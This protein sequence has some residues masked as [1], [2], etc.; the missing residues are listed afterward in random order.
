M[1]ELVETA[2]ASPPNPGEIVLRSTRVVTDGEVRAADVVVAGDRIREV[3]AHG[4]APRGSG[5]AVVDLDDDVLMP[6]LVDVHVHID[7]PPP[8]PFADGAGA[9]RQSDWEGFPSASRAA[10]A[11]GIGLLVDMPLNSEPVTTS[12]AALA[13]K[14]RAAS[15]RSL[16]DVAFHAGVVPANADDPRCLASL[17]LAGAA[18]FKCFLCDSGLATFPPVDRRALRAAMHHIAGLGRR[19]LAHAELL[20]PATALAAPSA[21]GATSPIGRRYADYLDSRPASAEVAAIALLIELARD[22]GCAVHV[23]HLATAAALPLLADAR[24]EGLDITVETCPHYLTFAAE[25]IADGDTVAKC[26]P[27][28]RDAANREALWRGLERGAIDFVASDHSPCPPQLKRRE[29]GDFGAAWGGIASLQLLLPAVWT[30]V[31]ARGLGLARLAD[32][33]AARPARW[34]GLPDRG[35][36][37]PGARADLVAF[38]PE[39][40]F[41]VRGAALEHRHPLTPYEGRE[42]AGVVRHTWL[43]GRAVFADGRLSL[44]DGPAPGAP[45]RLRGGFTGAENRGCAALARRPR[46]AA[47]DL[48]RRCCGSRRW[49]EETLDGFPHLSAR[50]LYA[51][52]EGAFD[53]L[54]EADWLEAFA[55]HPRIGDRAALRSGLSRSRGTAELESAEQAGAAAADEATLAELAAG[56]ARYEE[57]FGHVFLICASGLGAGEMLTALRLR[58]ANDSRAELAIAAEEQRK[59]TALR[60]ARLLGELEL[61]SE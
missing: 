26:A 17:A 21:V 47:A 43:G 32:W 23:V 2:M 27:P 25:E 12:V 51:A 35:T 53:A 3:T 7:D 14:I 9:L 54:D 15:G 18:A 36:I 39:E 33:L 50:G 22:T 42:L 4:A 8:G 55:A 34:L 5:V 40:R 13:A 6:A 37:L 30:G 57:R 59:I 16:V 46:A 38:R 1:R 45:V 28:I 58:L 60:L 19:L 11:G 44:P 52:S 61:E 29:S 10:A 41:V 31:Q 20:A 49:L 48:L 56:N 24:A